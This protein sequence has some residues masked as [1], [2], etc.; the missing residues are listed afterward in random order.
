MA[1][2]IVENG[3]TVLAKGYGEPRLG[4]GTP[5]DA[6]ILFLIGSTTKAITSA[7]LA[8]LVD[9]GKLGWDDRVVDRLPGF[10]MYDSWVT[11]EMT[12][13]DLLVHRSGLGLGAGDLLYIP[14]GSISRAEI[15]RR[16]RY[17]KPSGSFRDRY[18][19][20]NIL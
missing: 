13:R 14:R 11:R 3:R 15:V 16:L 6:E 5:V 10:Q 4:T 20:D 1:I 2:A 18:A 8:T 19:Y 17:L 12:V 7:A 9:S